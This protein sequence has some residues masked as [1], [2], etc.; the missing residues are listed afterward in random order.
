MKKTFLVFHTESPGVK[1][2]VTRGWFGKLFK[3][4]CFATLAEVLNQPVI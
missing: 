2:W 3:P 1:V 4:T